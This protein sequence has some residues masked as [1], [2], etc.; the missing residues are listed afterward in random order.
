[1]TIHLPTE[2]DRPILEYV[3]R[4]PYRTVDEFL[5][6]AVRLLHEQEDWLAAHRAAIAKLVEAGWASAARGEPRDGLSAGGDGGEK[7]RLDCAAASGMSAYAFTPEAVRNLV[8][9]R[10]GLGRQSGSGTLQS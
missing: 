7:A 6:Q 9:H 1:V 8:A 4:G 5:E 10:A 2:L 3:E